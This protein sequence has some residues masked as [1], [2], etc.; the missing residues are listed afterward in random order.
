MK[1]WLD[2]IR[3]APQGWIRVRSY[4]EAVA[5]IQ[6]QGERITE[7]SLDHDLC[8]HHVQGDFSDNQTGFDVLHFLLVSD[9]FQRRVQST[10][11]QLL[12]H[13]L[14][15]NFPLL[16]RSSRSSNFPS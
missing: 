10:G 8:E 9:G 12:D 13:K 16:S 15:H 14:D 4:Q 2:D 5:L 6:D 11:K 3:P 1:V 7:I